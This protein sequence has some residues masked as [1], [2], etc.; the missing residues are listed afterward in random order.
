MEILLL[1]AIVA[2]GASAL[3]VAAT[4]DKRTKQ[5]AEPLVDAVKGIS[6]RIDDSDE[7]LRRQLLAI[8][9]QRQQDKE[10]INQYMSKIQE[11]L[12]DAD[13]RISSIVGQFLAEMDT[14]KHQGAQIVTLQERFSGDLK[15]QLAHQVTHLGESLAQLSA[16]AQG[17]ETYIKS[18]ETQITANIKKFEGSL[19]EIGA[20]QS[21]THDELSSITHKLDRQTEM[22]TQRQDHDRW[23]AEQIMG[24]VRQIEALLHS[25]S[26]IESYLHARLDYEAGRTSHDHKCRVVTASLRLSGPGADLLWP[27]LL[28]FCETV[29]LKAVLPESPRP[30]DSRSYLLWQSSG[31]LH[32]EEV[33]S[34]KLA[35]CADGPASPN[36]DLEE[37]RSLVLG[38]HGAGPGTVQVGPMIINRTPRALLG[39][40]TAVAEPPGIGDARTLMSSDPD[41]CE[42][43]LRGLPQ[44]RITDL[45]SWADGFL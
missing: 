6:K 3:Y 7:D 29:M 41:A 26:V 13:R 12:D 35:A 23:A 39:C 8:I 5:N 22:N 11:R 33:L 18:R 40:V 21:A 17:I 27:L 32:L 44:G 24:T 14:I 15:Q 31:G 9:S 16:Q 42:A 34:A 4:L 20:R 1:V 2:V 28:S 36:L 10:L 25:Q 37:L 45:T 19:Q 43:A 30:A 38:L